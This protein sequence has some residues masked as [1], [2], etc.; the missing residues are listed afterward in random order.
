LLVRKWLI[1]E[2][3]RFPRVFSEHMRAHWRAHPHMWRACVCPL[4]RGGT[5][6]RES[7][8]SAKGRNLAR[9]GKP[10]GWGAAGAER[11]TPWGGEVCVCAV[12]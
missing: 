10:P 9:E 5:I 11:G 3:L 7:G 4:G 6:H 2:R 8:R 12:W 1:R